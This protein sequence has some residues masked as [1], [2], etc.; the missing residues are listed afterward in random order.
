MIKKILRS[1]ILTIALFVLGAGLLLFGGIGGIQAAPRIQS[2]FFGGQIELTEIHTAIAENGNI[3]ENASEGTTAE[4]ALLGE[5]FFQANDSLEKAGDF[6]LGTTYKEELSVVNSGSD[7]ADFE[8]GEAIPQYVR[9]TVYCYWVDKDGNKLV[10][11]D[12]GMIDLEF[13]EGNGWTIDQAATNYTPGKADGNSGERTVLYYSNIL[14]LGGESNPFTSAISVS[15]EVLQ[16]KGAD[17]KSIYDG[18]TFRIK[19]T[20]DAVQT[21][22][23]DEARM[24]AWGQISANG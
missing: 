10:N 18:A 13:V 19:A 20:V 12:P 4:G 23:E 8:G 15:P 17:G 14:D 1:P 7:D 16:K 9:V 5:Y 2:E 24:G 21:H 6:K 11:L 22:N 3:V